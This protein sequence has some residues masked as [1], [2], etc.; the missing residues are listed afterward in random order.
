MDFLRLHQR[1]EGA[2]G[3]F[4]AEERKLREAAPRISVENE[5]Y[6]PVTLECVWALAEGLDPRWRLFE[7]L[8]PAVPGRHMD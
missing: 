4:G 2:F 1:P 8:P 6:L 5:L 3:F 7:S